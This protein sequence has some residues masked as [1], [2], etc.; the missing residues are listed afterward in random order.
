[1][2]ADLRNIVRKRNIFVFVAVKVLI[3][4]IFPELT[5]GRSD[6]VTSN[7]KV[8]RLIGNLSEKLQKE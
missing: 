4:V 3:L 2:P 8:K 1:M 6:I 5:D 7:M